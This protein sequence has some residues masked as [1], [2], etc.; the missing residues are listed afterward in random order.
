MKNIVIID[1]LGLFFLIA[2]CLF[3]GTVSIMAFIG[4]FWGFMQAYNANA[5]ATILAT[6]IVSFLV[7]ALSGIKAATKK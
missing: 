2:T 5:H 4:G 6:V 3:I 1:I 7:F